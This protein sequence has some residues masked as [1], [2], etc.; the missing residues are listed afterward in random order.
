MIRLIV[1][2]DQGNAIGWS[3]GRLAYSGLKQDMQRFKELTTGGVVIMGFN[4]F[5]SLGR[6]NGLPNRRNIVLTRKT[7]AEIRGV[8]GDDV[9]VVSTMEYVKRLS[10]RN[11]DLNIWLIG[12]K[13]VYEQALALGIVDELHIT[14]IHS[15][16][17]ADIRL[18]TDLAAWKLFLL[19]QGKQGTYWSVDVGDPQW[20]GDVQT[21]YLTMRKLQNGRG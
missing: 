16:C 14:L 21:T 11:P 8:F 6:P 9:E 2:I 18:D 1:A 13:S 4:T 7:L 15:N 5:K 3:D 19:Q 12:G 17:E 10:E 20:D